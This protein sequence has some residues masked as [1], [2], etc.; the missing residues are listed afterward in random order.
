LASDKPLYQRTWFIIVMSVLF[1]SIVAGSLGG[2]NDEAQSPTPQPTVTVTATP[3]PTEDNEAVDS[4]VEA[5]TASPSP[6]P[7]EDPNSEESITYFIISSNGQFRDLEKD[8]R[9]ARKRAEADETFRLL[10]N[11][12]EFSFNLGQLR[13]LDPPSSIA[14]DWIIGI[15]KLDLAISKSSDAASDFISGTVS[16]SQMLKAL[17]RV[18]AQVDNMRRITDSIK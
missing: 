14:D 7:T 3:T 6:T 5:K 9:D 10:G 13:S 18:Q 12:L 1:L 8:I 11:I 15:D 16:T 4:E 17:N 2:A